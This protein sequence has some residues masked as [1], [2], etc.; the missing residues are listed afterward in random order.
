MER[1]A[2]GKDIKR[3][4]KLFTAV[5]S[6][7]LDITHISWKILA[8][9]IGSLYFIFVCSIRV[10]QTFH[11]DSEIYFYMIEYCPLNNIWNIEKVKVLFK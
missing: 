4:N 9:S 1:N 6:S 3:Q 8:F 11:R 5:F 10:G 2:C 7:H